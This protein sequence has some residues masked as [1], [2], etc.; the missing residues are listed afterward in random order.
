MEKNE[1]NHTPAAAW[2]ADWM[3]AANS[4]WENM[5]NSEA[6][7]PR[8]F[9]L[10]GKSQQEKIQKSWESGAK[11]LQA[12]AASL[13][14]PETVE[15]SLK[16]LDTVPEIMGTLA[17]QSWEGSLD[18]QKQW[19]ER[20]GKVDQTTR[21]CCFEDLDQ[22]TFRSIRDLYEKE[23]R[24]FLQVPQ[25]G[26]NRFH[27]EKVNRLIDSQ[28]I[29]QTALGEFLYMFCL[30]FEKTA[31]AMQEKLEQMAAAGEL[32]D[33]A[34]AYYNMWIKV[35][36]GQYMT[37]LQSPE[38]AEAMDNAITSFVSFKSAREEVLCD[39]LKSLPIPTNQ[40]MD[41]L[42]KDVHILKK[43]FRELSKRLDAGAAEAEH[44]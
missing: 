25:L 14:R 42:Y 11:M 9:E 13:G 40:D 1:P 29:F 3:D 33:D 30:P 37:L 6:G 24:K 27:Q 7:G 28:T 4:L 41:A 20:M 8:M 26:L 5:S 35:L 34:K 18:L 12:M 44:A 36:E 23:L 17:R 22:N 16:G 2:I 15:A 31:G 10:P 39:M 43:K 38:Y 19:L 32:H 21:S